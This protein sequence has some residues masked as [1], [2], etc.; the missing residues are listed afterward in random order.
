MCVVYGYENIVHISW[1]T[2]NCGHKT[3]CQNKAS[4]NNKMYNI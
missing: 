4:F 2:E 3:E 1:G